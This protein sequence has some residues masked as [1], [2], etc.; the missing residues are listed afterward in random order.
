MLIRLPW[1][2][3]SWSPTCIPICRLGAFSDD[4]LWPDICKV[5]RGLGNQLRYNNPKPSSFACPRRSARRAFFSLDFW[6]YRTVLKSCRAL[7]VGADLAPARV[8]GV[9]RLLCSRGT[10]WLACGR[11]PDGECY[12]RQTGPE[13]V[14]PR[15]RG[16]PLLAR[17]PGGAR[18]GPFLMGLVHG[19]G[20]TLLKGAV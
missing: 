14:R 9:R 1:S 7:C 5:T 16:L 19:G 15:M 12:P 8:N 20:A 3:P 10:H 17:G 6:I 11:I 13:P 18:R 4:Q 2:T